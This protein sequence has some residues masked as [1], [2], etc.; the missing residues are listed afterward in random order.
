MLLLF[1]CLVIGV[2]I[3]L[4]SLNLINNFFKDSVIIIN[5]IIFI[6][7]MILFC[8]SNV[9]IF[10]FFVFEIN[11][12]LIMVVNFVSDNLGCLNRIKFVEI[13]IFKSIVGMVGILNLV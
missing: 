12:V 4:I 1:K 10:V 3:W 5:V 6:M 7:L 13:K 2:I 8:E 9:L 11:F